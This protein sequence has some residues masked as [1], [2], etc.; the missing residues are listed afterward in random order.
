MTGTTVE[1]YA[2]EAMTKLARLLAGKGYEEPQVRS[3]LAKL[4]RAVCHRMVEAGYDD[5]LDVDE[6]AGQ[7]LAVLAKG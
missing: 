3:M 2:I 6:V 5:G 1:Q 4:P 7:I